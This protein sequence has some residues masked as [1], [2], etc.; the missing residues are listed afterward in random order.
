MHVV[1]VYVLPSQ[2]NSLLKCEMCAA[3]KGKKNHSLNTWKYKVKSK[4]KKL[5][6]LTCDALFRTRIWC[7]TVL[8]GNE[9]KILSLQLKSKKYYFLLV[10]K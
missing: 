6:G 8:F 10:T 1:L 5:S 7:G 2:H 9:V 3:A 4:H